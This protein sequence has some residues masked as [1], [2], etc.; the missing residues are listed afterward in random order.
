ML[1]RIISSFQMNSP[2]T[3][4]PWLIPTLRQFIFSMIFCLIFKYTF[5]TF[6]TSDTSDTLTLAVGFSSKWE[7]F[8]VSNISFVV[9]FCYGHCAVSWRHIVEVR[10]LQGQIWFSIICWNYY[11]LYT[12]TLFIAHIVIQIS[13]GFASGF[14]LGYWLI[15]YHMF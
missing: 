7:H 14:S 10:A 1:A 13:T 8:K 15:T 9:C 11:T 6:N 5:D 12:L 2:D 4:S 3:L